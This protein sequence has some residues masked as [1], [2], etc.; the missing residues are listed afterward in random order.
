MSRQIGFTIVEAVI[1]QPQNVATTMMKIQN[2]YKFRTFPRYV[3]GVTT[4]IT[5]SLEQ[6]FTRQSVFIRH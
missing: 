1:M 4:S 6:L 5:A 3:V 2:W